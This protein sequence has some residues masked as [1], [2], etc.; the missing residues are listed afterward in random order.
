MAISPRRQYDR[1]L[2]ESARSYFAF[3]C[4]LMKPRPPLLV[5]IG[6]LSGTGKSALA[7]S[8]APELPPIPGAVVLRSDIERKAL[9]G[10][11][12]SERLPPEAYLCGGFRAHLRRA[13]AQSRTHHCS[14]ALSH[15]RCGLC[16]T[17]RAQIFGRCCSKPWH[18][19]P[20]IVFGCQPADPACA[21]RNARR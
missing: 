9:F 2:A 19:L 7:K 8:L 20:R 18:S 13:P 17:G 6:G 15:C 11:S 21:N 1:L 12:E 3:A 16:T 10:C 4:R 14:G 5:A